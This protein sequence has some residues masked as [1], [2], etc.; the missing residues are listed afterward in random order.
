LIYKD[1]H[2]GQLNNITTLVKEQVGDKVYFLYHFVS[3]D[4]SIWMFSGS[5]LLKIELRT[6]VFRQYLNLPVT[7]ENSVGTSMRGMLEDANGNIWI[8]SYGYMQKGK[9]YT[10]HT[11]HPQDGTITSPQLLLSAKVFEKNYLLYKAVMIGNYLY[12]VTDGNYFLKIDIKKKQ[13]EEVKEFNDIPGNEFVT[14]TAINDSTLWMGGSC[15]A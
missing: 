15:F 2:T 1:Q 12:A 4:N 11:L 13:L 10:L 5:A 6:T 9:T 14:I 8:C 7:K 3:R